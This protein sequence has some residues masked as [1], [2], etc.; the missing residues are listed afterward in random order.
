MDRHDRPSFE[1][2]PTSLI[3]ISSE[4]TAYL[5]SLLRV[6]PSFEAYCRQVQEYLGDAGAMSATLASIESAMQE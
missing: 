3:N 6:D 4:E 1:Y 2:S 5:V